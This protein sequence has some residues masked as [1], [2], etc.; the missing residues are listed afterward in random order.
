MGFFAALLESMRRPAGFVGNDEPPETLAGSRPANLDFLRP[1]HHALALEPRVM[2]DGAAATAATDPNHQGDATKAPEAPAAAERSTAS[3]TRTEAAVATVAS[4]PAAPAAPAQSL[5]VVDSRVE[6]QEMLSAQAG[7]GVT[8]LVVNS[9]EDGLAAISAA[10]ANM[11]QV[12]S[13]QIL[14]HGASGQFTLGNR[15]ISSDNVGQL[16][17][18]L[19]GW[20]A[21]LTADADIQLYGCSIGAGAAGQTLVNELARLT[22]ADVGASTDATGSAAEGGNWTLETRAGDVDKALAL[23]AATVESFQGLLADASPTVTLSSGG[24]DVLLGD[25]FTFTASFTNP[26]S[27]VGFAPY[28]DLYIPTTGKD[29]AGAEVDD[30]ITFVSA[31]FQGV[32]IKSYDVVFDANGQAVHPLAKGPDGQPLIINAS[33]YGLRAGDHMVVLQLPNASIVSGQPPIDIVV[34]M[35][36]SS[37]ADTS[38]TDAA[39]NLTVKA[40]GGFQFGNTSADD[41]T[42]DP[43]LLE[44]GSH[45]FVVHPTMV[46]LTMTHNIPD[47][48]TVS[49]PNYPR[50]FTITASTASDQTLTNVK[51]EQ[52]LPN[53][54]MVTGIVPGANG[55][56]TSITLQDGTVITDAGTIASTLA[57][58]AYLSHF[59]LTY[60]TL[61]GSQ[62]ATVNFYVPD[63]DSNGQQILDPTT[64]APRTITIDGTDA[65]AQWTPLDTRDVPLDPDAALTGTGDPISFQVLSMV[66]Y[67]PTPVVSTDVGTAGPTPGDTLTYTLDVDIS[68]YFAFGRDVVNEGV[69]E[70]SDLASNGQTVVMT[71]GSATLTVFIGGQQF[72]MVMTPVVVTNPDGTTSM[73]LDI[74]QTLRDNG[75]ALAALVGDLAFD[76]AINGATRAI[77]TYQVKVDQFYGTPSDTNAVNEGDTVGNNAVITGTV[78]VDRITTG[79]TVSDGD[80]TTVTVP[81]STVDIE[82]LTVDGTAVDPTQPVELH[83]GDV[84]T[85]QI[86]YDLVTGDY[87]DFNLSAYLPLPLFDVNGITWTQGANGVD[88]GVNQ[89]S[90]GSGHTLGND[91]TGPVIGVVNGN[92]IRFDFGDHSSLGETGSRIELR[93][94]MVVGDQPFGDQRNVTVIAQSN[95]VTTPGQPIVS[96]DAALINSIAEPVLTIT[97]GVVSTS[98]P[99]AVIT[100]TTGTWAPPGDTT[101]P[102]FTLPLNDTTFVNGDITGI[103]GGDL[104]RMATAI[105]NSGGGGA[106]DVSTR[107]DLPAGTSFVGGDLASTLRV[108]RGDGTILQAGIDYT[109]VGNVVTFLDPVEAQASLPAGRPGTAADTSGSNLVVLLYDVKVDDAIAASSTMQSQGVLTHYASVKGGD[110]FVPDGADI[111]EKAGEQVSAPTVKVVYAG[112]TLDN[113]DSS[114]PSTT[115]SNLV[116]G[117]TMDYDIV[118]TIPEGTTTNLR[119]DELIPPGMALDMSFNGGQGYEIIQTVAGSAAL[120]ADFGGTLTGDTPTGLGG[121]VG[122][123]GVDA[124]LSFTASTNNADNVSGNNSFVIRVRLVAS[125]T[126]DNQAGRVLNNDVQLTYSD[127]DGDQAGGTALDRTVANSGG[128]PSVTVAEPTL[129]ISQS[130]VATGSSLGVDQGNTV[131]Y[132]IVISNNSGVDAYDVSFVDAFPTNLLTGLSLDSVTY[133]GSV[134]TAGGTTTDFVLGADGVLRTVNGA[135][136][137][138]G[139]GGSITIVVTGTVTATAVN[140]QTIDNT[141]SVQWTSINDA[142]S[143]T[144]AGGERTGVDGLLNSGVLNDYQVKADTQVKVLSGIQVS[145]IGGMA[146]TPSADNGTTTDGAVEQVAVGEIVRYRVVAAVGE[147]VT[148]DYRIQ[149]TLDEGLTFMEDGTIKIAIVSSN[150][151]GVT[152]NIQLNSDGTLVV[153]G[154][155]SSDIAQPIP[156]D[157]SN[158]PNATLA[159]GRWTVS[160]DGRT[161]VFDLGT[162]TN[163]DADLDPTDLEGVVIEFNARV[164]NVASNQNGTVLGMTAGIL[165]ADNTLGARDSVSEQVIEP[166]FTGMVKQVDS[167]V[168]NASGT[169]STANMSVSFTQNGTGPAYDVTLDDP[170]FA[171]ANGYTLT[172]VT[173]IL[174]DGTTTVVLPADFGANGITNTSDATGIHLSVDKVDVGTKVV[175]NYSVT[176]GVDTAYASTDAELKW[177][178]L[179]ETFTTWGGTAVG[180]DATADG[181]RNGSDGALNDYVLREGAGL[182]VIHGN[183]WDDSL[184][185]TGD[186]T[187]DGPALAGQ[188]VTLRWAGADGALDTGDD[189]LFT[190]VTDSAGF[191]HFSALA[192][193]SYRVEA[194]GSIPLAQPTGEVRVRLDTDT[195]TLGQVTSTVAEG[196]TQRGDFAYVQINDAPINSDVPGP[197]SV[198]EDTLLQIPGFAVRDFD[199]NQGPAPGV[200]DVTLTVQ[201]GV[202]DFTATPAGTLV[203]TGKG[204]GTITL[205]GSAADINAVLGTLT[206]QGN[207]N[208]NGPD[209]LTITTKDRGSFGDADGDGIPGEP[210]DDQLQDVDTVAINVIPVNDPPQGN[211]DEAAAV[212]AG[213]TD[214]DMPG[215]DPS[216]NLLANDT[217]VDIATNND[218]LQLVS[219]T[220]VSGTATQVTDSTS[221]FAVAGRYGTLYV[222]ANGAARYEVDNDNVEVQAL[223]TTS[224]SLSE[225][226]SYVLADLGGLQSGAILRVTIQG[227]NDTPVGADDTGSALEAGGVNNN[228]PGAPATGNVLLGD[229]NGGVA[230][231]D[232]D[233]GETATDPIDYGERLSVTGA[234]NVPKDQAGSLTPMTGGAAVVV[235]KYGTLTIR[236]DGSY[237]YVVNDSDPAVQ[238]LS[239]G[240]TLSDVF[241]YEVSDVGGLSSLANLTIVIKGAFDNPVASDDVAQA[242]A[243]GFEPDGV[244]PLGD[245]TNPSGNVIT[246]ISRPDGNPTPGNGVDTDID[247]IDQPNTE[248][249]VTGARTGQESAGGTLTGLTN[250][251]IVLQGQ[252]GTLTLNA[253]G[254]YTYD[255]DS[256]N[257]DVIAKQAGSPPLQDYFTYQ[258]T[259]HGG[260]TD[261]AQLLINVSGANDAP[262]ANNVNVVAVE[263]G[264]V[265]N[266]TAG[267]DPSGDATANDT[268]PDGDTLTVV[269]IRTGAEG[270]GTGTT[271]PVGQPLAGLYGTL[272]IQPNGQFTYVLDN[273]NPLVQ[274]LRTPANTLSE[275]FTY[276]IDDGEGGQDTAEIII[277]IVGRNDNPVATDDAGQVVESGGVN[278][279]IPGLDAKGNVLIGDANGG[280]ADTDVDGASYG[281]TKTVTAIGLGSEAAPGTAGSVG[282]ELRGTY[283]WITL[284]ADGNYTYRLDNSMP[285]VEALRTSGNTLQEQFHYTVSD[286][287]GAT[288]IATLTITIVG[289]NDAPVAR[290][291][292]GTAVEA[293]GTDNQTLG[294]PATGNVLANDSDV[295]GGTGD[296]ID[297][298]ETMAVQSVAQGTATAAAGT[299]LVAQYGTLTLGADGNYTYVIDDNDPTVQALRPGQTLT[300]TFT[301]TIVDAAGAVSTARL[302]IT[303]QG[304]D[305]APVAKDDAGTAVEQGGV[306]NSTGG[307]NA[308]GNVLLGDAN[309][310]VADT[311]IDTP[312]TLLNVTGVR[313]GQEA[314]TGTGGT[315]GVALVG[316]YGTLTLNRDGS[317]TY[318]IDNNNAEVQALRQAG[319]TL[320]DYFTYTVSD[321]GNLSDTAQLTITIRGA[322]DTPVTTNDT[323]SAIE[324]GGLDNG[325]PGTP[326]TGNVLDNDDDVD[327]GAGD[328]IDYGETKAVQDYTHGTATVTAGNALP[329][330]YGSV[331]INADGS[332]TYTVDE[333][334]ATVQAL[335]TDTDTLTEVFTYT[336][337]DAA[338]ATS[339]ATL[340][341]TIHGRNDTPEAQ[342]DIGVA[343]EA[344]GVNN[345]TPGSPAVGNVLTNDIDVDGTN[346]GETRA[347][348]GFSQGANTGTVGNAFT[349]QY[350]SLTLNADGSYT[351]V[352]DNANAAVQALR[353][354]TDTLTEVFSYTMVDASGATSTSTLTITIRGA[355]DNPVATNDTGTAVEAGGVDNGTPGSPA[356]GNVLLGD[357]NGGVPDTDVDGGAGDP[358]D[359]GETMA[360]QSYRQGLRSATAGNALA[361]AYGSL[362]INADGSYTYTVDDDNATVQALL[363]GQTLTEVFVYTVRDTAGAI[364]TATL[365]LTIQGADD[366]PTAVIDTAAAVEAGGIDNGTAGVDPSGNVLANDGDVDNPGPELRVIG[367][368][369][370]PEIG[371]GTAGTLG[372][373]LVGLYGTLTLNADG[374]YTYVVDNDNPAVQA[375]RQS[376]DV[377]RDFFTYT[378]RDPGGQT[379]SAMLVITVHGANDTPVARDD[380]G[381]AVEAGGVN[382]TTPGS[383]SLGNVLDNDTD[384]DSVANGE[385]K[386]VV[387]YTSAGTG[388]VGDAGGAIAGLYGS[389]VINADGSWRYVVDNDNPAVQAMRTRGETLTESFSYLMRDT[390]GATSR[391]NLVIVVQGA[392]DNPVARDDSNVATDQVVAP[393]ATGNVLPNDSDVDGGDALHVGAVRTGAEAGSGTAGVIGQALAG[394]YGTLVLNADGSYT[395]SID[396]T[397]P[398]VLAAAGFGQ[399]LQ[400]VFTYTLVDRAGATDLAQ[401][402]IHLD[403]SAPRIDDGDPLYFQRLFFR[404][405][406]HEHELGYEPGIFVQPVVRQNAFIDRLDQASSDGTRLDMVLDRGLVAPPSL[407]AGLG[408]VTGQFVGEVVRESQLAAQLELARL[409]GR[410][411]RVS[412]DADGLLAD[413]SLFSL[414]DAGLTK[415]EAQRPGLDASAAGSRQTADGRPGDGKSNGNRPKQAR[416][417]APAFSE[418]L[419]HAA[420]QSASVAR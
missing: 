227:A 95:Q 79:G 115:G 406:P 409:L 233:G 127:P 322:N 230:D 379:D 35:R 108:I 270:D 411:G 151:G 10:L 36:L 358:V 4:A 356:T 318:V 373:A 225:Q 221:E 184:S 135:N 410:H 102:P 269:N 90:Y 163:T 259:D 87:Q 368:R 324:A 18:Q 342:P 418:Q 401:L 45:D 414:T 403:I 242:Q 400:D 293:G 110:D 332:Y 219:V 405:E 202:L 249:T 117:E 40:R 201:N 8:V 363:P 417:T 136:I 34:T 415:G 113:G 231:T 134:T 2:F 329:G 353:Q 130:A 280:V 360:V 229:A 19:Q 220:G 62:D 33:T 53:T 82:V 248:L 107:I 145:R 54:I 174:A 349:A 344:G 156:A 187:P 303:I 132:T 377:L 348:Q 170:I 222:R 65:S 125:N 133:T 364:S 392:N 23:S 60:S 412:L 50:S 126:Q 106:F 178:S 9:N 266:G 158:G 347:V 131:T 305:D 350:G 66:V 286:R 228:T 15:T 98:S 325:V 140:F 224:Q 155:R 265:N 336:M 226:F 369:T 274:A 63:V 159:T 149:V 52:D 374:S 122:Q 275:R 71:P 80:A 217:D 181:E 391:A 256:T 306:G 25:T 42:I 120:T 357:A 404:P 388:V 203:F 338:G 109:V 29:G 250:G 310:G 276:T 86:S 213:G 321:D 116:V 167:F 193:G 297:Y 27:Q 197:Q 243:Q 255:V 22:G 399:I 93:F 189:Q 55:T 413:P 272:T 209:T 200:L 81:T 176:V 3:A 212:E 343:A 380:A 47:G 304:A 173:I 168:P 271:V 345:G 39:P 84:V 419:R 128:D 72:N 315:V 180:T 218:V 312:A 387:S 216:L 302:T 386:Q 11:G 260:L 12:D 1:Q 334:N 323:G 376:G 121:T 420:G 383:D 24:S 393:Q 262:V 97:H 361:G 41:P 89:W 123:D 114:S 370:G 94:T 331:V 416:T 182:G 129:T 7:P 352:V 287:A 328:P 142:A 166:S 264:G 73:K 235:G 14:S 389:L 13:I 268:D 68:D 359:Y 282:V 138:I 175:V 124:R 103:D 214:N 204:T 57:A 254:S 407:G 46:D 139:N 91:V 313:T 395:Y 195:G 191:F 16:A 150:N 253:D 56:V 85:F 244:T 292:A 283:G 330:A 69:L 239:T 241:S 335:R 143:V 307:S 99:D 64:G 179:P 196:G 185:A 314:G 258:I 375:L 367:V 32:E 161:I 137:D 215:I 160:A 327:G 251:S 88:P 408:Q 111:I 37:L 207:L 385:S 112:G 169:T 382:N 164:N 333:N 362:V 206:Y 5:L 172:S 205:S 223:R 43:S 101:S 245:E 210:V 381:V 21:E 141:S 371:S 165:A 402:T 67:K 263:A 17:G 279:N 177:S 171:G 257:P 208:F 104:L 317:Y 31:T 261:T 390:A 183:L 105:E 238:A 38:L 291:D 70:I 290:D 6:Q 92:Y 365:T 273:N 153:L 397:N 398:E 58:G 148:N 59:E 316:R 28:I 355:N 100:G 26:S 296:P 78:L 118:V 48:Q 152:S 309:G 341:L 61:T 284:N 96:Q 30:G 366:A 394:R 144:S 119:I 339:T 240:Q 267:V 44:A 236:G 186:L 372:Q 301:Y 326:A 396:M 319:N 211:N 75:Q 337:R 199:L 188:T 154:N 246:D 295:D 277:R 83:P 289:A 192:A 278:N 194:P 300:E 351:Y 288:D 294:S 190:T 74:A 298:G 346:Y 76:D 311:D 147:G 340:T 157:L 285:A 247:A 252:Y 146:D 77:I 354:S 51:V 198:D 281:E 234:R 378:M 232:V 162:L 320:Q 49:G 299:A 20:S 308:I 384:V 237:E